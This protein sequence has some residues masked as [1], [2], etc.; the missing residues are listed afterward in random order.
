ML[1]DFVAIPLDEFDV[2]TLAILSTLSR[3]LR[4]VAQTLGL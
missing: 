2:K 1:F 3:G 4:G